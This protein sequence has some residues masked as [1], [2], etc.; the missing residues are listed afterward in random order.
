MTK[1]FRRLGLVAVMAAA[2]QLTVLVTPAQAQWPPQV[3]LSGICEDGTDPLPAFSPCRFVVRYSPVRIQG[4]YFEVTTRAGNA[5][6][7]ADYVPL[8]HVRVQ[9]P[10][11]A[12][13]S[14][15][16]VYVVNDGVCEQPESFTLVLS[17][18]VLGRSVVETTRVITDADC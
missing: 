14:Y 15:I 10:P 13:G 18:G 17:G 4:A 16:N 12:S 3:M 1:L 11:S 2:V 9:V 5:T 7:Q 6:P 8:D